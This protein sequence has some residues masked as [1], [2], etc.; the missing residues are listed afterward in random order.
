LITDVAF[1]QEPLTVLDE[2][3]EYAEASLFIDSFIPVDP[4]NEL[5]PIGSRVRLDI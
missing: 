1:E 4:P 5:I 2:G 3:R